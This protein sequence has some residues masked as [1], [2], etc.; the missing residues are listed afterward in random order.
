[1]RSQLGTSQNSILGTWVKAIG[2]ALDAAGCD[3]PMLLGQAG[4]DLTELDGPDTRCPLEN[5]G[6]L[7]R[8]A[9]S[10]TQDEAFGVKLAKYYKHTTF[11]ALGFGISASSTLK[12]AFERVQRYSHVVSDAV[13]YQFSRRGGE[14]HLLILPTTDVPIESI[15]ALVGM[16]IR[17]CRAGLGPS[18]S[19]LSLELRRSRPT[20]ID[21]FEQEWRTPTKFGAK[22]DRII[23]DKFSIERLL[24]S[25]NPELARVSDDISA[26]YLA[27]IDRYNLEARVREILTQRIC[28]EEPSQ[29]EVAA[30]LNVSVRTLQRKLRENGTNFKEVWDETRH[31]LALAYLS[32]SQ[33]SIS[34]VTRLLGFSCSSSFTRSFRRWTGLSPSD[35][36]DR[37]ASR[38]LRSHQ[39]STAEYCV[40]APSFQ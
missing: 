7:W 6:R 35:W 21:E 24:D 20:A 37:S 36:R 3:G 33:R 4:L 10:A 23:F 12:E 26:R 13:E 25:G 39:R 5:A 28:T 30:V 29:S 18:Y 27:R 31:A 15:D 22:Q 40:R 38:Y 9:L 8:I 34:E 11:H 16:F 32:T 1:V 14:Y 19:P 2:R 17:T